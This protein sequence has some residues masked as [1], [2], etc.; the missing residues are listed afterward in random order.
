MKFQLNSRIASSTSR[1]LRS[2][3]F[4]HPPSV[5]NL[6]KTVY[7]GYPALKMTFN[8]KTPTLGTFVDGELNS[9]YISE[10]EELTPQSGIQ[11]LLF[12]F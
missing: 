8:T 12:L 4:N 5:I 9:N 11:A 7:Q 2:V 10:T 1:N 6:N 3:W